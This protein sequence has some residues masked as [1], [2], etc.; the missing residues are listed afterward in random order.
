MY[1]RLTE[2]IDLY[3]LKIKGVIHIGGHYG[4]EYPSYR[5]SGIKR[6]L[7][8]EPI[9]DNFRRMVD[10]FRSDFPDIEEFP[11][12]LDV[13]NT[14]LDLHLIALNIALGNTAGKFPMFVETA[15]QSQSCSLLK[16]K[17]HLEQYPHIT[18]DDQIE[19]TLNKLDNLTFDKNLNAISIDVQGFELEVFK[20][21]INTISRQIDYIYS[22]V[23]RDELYEG[24]PMVE[25]LDAFLSDSGFV[26]VICDWVGGTWGDALYMKQHLAPNPTMQKILPLRFS[27]WGKKIWKLMGR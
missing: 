21:G 11:A 13:T 10:T 27:R 24:C 17:K 8:I 23:N 2:L 7:F 16:P 4:E 1:S 22:E 5:S 20:G 9:P 15:N 6:F 25:E 14:K 19:I 12:A 3:R 26:R 18:F